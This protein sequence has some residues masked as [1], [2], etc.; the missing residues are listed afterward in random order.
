MASKLKTIGVAFIAAL[1]LS[2]LA[3]SSAGATE[4]TASSYPAA[5]S[6]GRW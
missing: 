3:A 2:G 6:A 5:Y 1:A 4:F